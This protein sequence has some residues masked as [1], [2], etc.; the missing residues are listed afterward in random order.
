MIRSHIHRFIEIHNSHPIRFQ[1]NREHYLPTGQPFLMYYYPESGKNYHEK[2]NET[3]LAA[4]EKEVEN[5]DLDEYLPKATRT[6]YEQFLQEGGYPDVFI[7]SDPRHK[8]AYVYLR[9]RVSQFIA[10]GNQVQLVSRPA[11]A[12]EWIAANATHEIE[13]HRGNVIG[14]LPD[15]LMQL[16]P[17][18]DEDEED[19]EA[20][21]PADFKL[22]E[23]EIQDTLSTLNKNSS[24][25]PKA[26]ESQATCKYFKKNVLLKEIKIT[27]L[28]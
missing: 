27:N 28:I 14:Q 9:D 12:A 25:M 23:Q 7:Y 2:V 3:V 5:Y 24:N 21:E 1:R 20:T 10:D 15:T 16:V 13:M 8:D 4:L 22:P 18:D 11:G 26:V 17:T 6:L 19:F